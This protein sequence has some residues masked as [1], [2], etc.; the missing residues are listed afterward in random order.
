MPPNDWR[1]ILPLVIFFLVTF[2]FTWWMRGRGFREFD[3]RRWK[4]DDK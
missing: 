4:Q 2:F 3:P 1:A